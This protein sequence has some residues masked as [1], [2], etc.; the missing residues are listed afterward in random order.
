MRLFIRILSGPERVNRGANQTVDK[1]LQ[2]QWLLRDDRGQ[3][4]AQGE[5][6]AGGL[7]DMASASGE[8]FGEPFG[9]PSGKPDDLAD[10]DNLV[11]VVPSA[12]V[13][14]LSRT[15]PGR[16][17]AQIRRA[18]PFAVEEDLTQDVE[19]MHLAH[20]PIVRGQPVRCALIDRHLLTDW[21]T[22]LGDCGLRPGHMVPDACLLPC[23]QSSASVLLE[24]DEALV[25]TPEHIATVEA[26]TLPDILESIRA[27][28][29]GADETL[30]LDVI[31]PDASDW[32]VDGSGFNVRRTA[33]SGTALDFLASQW[34]ANRP[35][36]NLLQG[37]FAPSRGKLGSR[38]GW[39]GVAGLAALWLIVTLA[40][41]I[42]E[43]YVS[44][45]R[46]AALE[47]E[48]TAL[49]R[50]IYPNERRVPN[51]YAQMRAKLRESDAGQAAF[52]VLLGQLA[53]GTTQ[54]NADVNVRAITFNDS[55]GELTTEL[56]LPG[57]ALLDELKLELEGRGLTVDISSAEERD[58]IVRARLRIRMSG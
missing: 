46:A 3:T 2:C 41:L 4:L 42:A 56:W 52:H 47:A 29:D 39:R 43:G 28:F 7:G 50:S 10:P 58:S 45:H 15:V 21:L 6:D 9:E 13:A 27:S 57:Y 12:Q 53:A 25:R 1:T 55:R 36:I 20:G 14:W 16:R 11:V 40:V 8:P 44:N 30:E 51:A 37:P 54:G 23:N 31:G 38:N 48:S 35:E 19:S 33:L 18:L 26:S 22:C 34:D 24:G 49:Y 5:T 32:R 17:A